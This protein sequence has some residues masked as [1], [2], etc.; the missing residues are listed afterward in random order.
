M[1]MFIIILII[2]IYCRKS[3]FQKL[4]RF[5]SEVGTNKATPTGNNLLKQDRTALSVLASVKKDVY[6]A[7]TN[8]LGPKH[9]DSVSILRKKR[10]KLFAET[11]IF[12][13]DS[14]K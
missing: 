9:T 4:F 7:G 13:Q 14:I 10:L 8:S 6:F 2:S 12:F 5:S 1:K 11:Q 3:F